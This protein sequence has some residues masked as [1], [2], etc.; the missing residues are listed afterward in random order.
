MAAAC[1]WKWVRSHKLLTAAGAT[2]VGGAA[3]Y[4]F[5]DSLSG[6]LK[7]LSDRLLKFALAQEMGRM[8]EDARGAGR[9][10]VFRET[11]NAARHAAF[12]FLP[13]I[14][15]R[16][17]Q[18]LNKKAVVKSLRECG[19]EAAEGGPG[20]EG[21]TSL[22]KRKIALWGELVAIQV[23]QYA[24]AI[25]ASSVLIASFR[26][27]LSVLSRHKLDRQSN[28]ERSTNS[29]DSDEIGGG[30]RKAEPFS[31]S[32]DDLG[33]QDTREA[34]HA[35][36]Y[37]AVDTSLGPIA[38]ACRQAAEDVLGDAK[39]LG[40]TFVTA[41]ELTSLVD[42]VLGGAHELLFS[43]RLRSKGYS[44]DFSAHTSKLDEPECAAAAVICEANS[45]LCSTAFV[46]V[47]ASVA[48]G[49][50]KVYADVLGNT[51]HDH[52]PRDGACAVDKAQVEAVITG[53][54]KVE[55]SVLDDQAEATAVMEGKTS[56]GG[57]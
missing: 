40:T 49:V 15:K 50:A 42:K 45:M 57:A 17:R 18:V 39:W 51:I 25:Y 48:S 3:A 21:A 11:G 37:Q 12:M 7:P 2:A 13:Q 44:H 4:V 26:L 19:K 35:H 22:K 47:L 9:Q 31:H 10:A 20:S 43:A 29:A 36:A 41:N 56:G 24:A 46:D 32:L 33:S 52:I 5:K 53:L 34:L 27:H 8:K 16:L 23:A 54:A 28:H 38:S 14:E 30:E 1:V 55:I 6:A